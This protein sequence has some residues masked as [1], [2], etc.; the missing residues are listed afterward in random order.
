MVFKT[1]ISSFHLLDYKMAYSIIPY[2]IFTVFYI[3]MQINISMAELWRNNIKKTFQVFELLL[4][5]QNGSSEDGTKTP[6]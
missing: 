4:K 1:K 5:N 6:L 2:I 3:P